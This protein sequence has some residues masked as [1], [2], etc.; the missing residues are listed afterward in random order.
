MSSRS[1]DPTYST[2]ECLCLPS[3]PPS[4]KKG[5]QPRN[6]RSELSVKFTKRCFLH[7]DGCASLPLVYIKNACQNFI[8]LFCFLSVLPKLPPLPPYEPAEKSQIK[9]QYVQPRNSTTKGTSH[10][11]LRKRLRACFAACPAQFKTMLTYIYICMNVLPQT[12]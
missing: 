5:Q 9:S 7:S 8:C 3:S 11:R 6:V 1:K 2:H 12:P 10:N 4:N